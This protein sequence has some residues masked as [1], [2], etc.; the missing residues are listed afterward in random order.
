MKF[1]ICLIQPTGYIHSL[2][3]LEAA[4]YIFY[5]IKN[6]GY[7]VQ[8]VKNR[9]YPTG[10]NIIFG[11]HINPENNLDFPKNT[12]IFNTEQLP[13]N[14]DWVNKDYREILQK[15]FVWDYSKTNLDL[16]THPNKDLVNFYYEK[17]LIR[18]ALD[19]SKPYDLAF[20]GSINDRRKVI[21]DKLIAKGLKVKVI[22]GLYGKERDEAIK[23]CKAVLN[24]HFYESKIFQQIRAFYPL[25]NGIPVI[26]ENFPTESAPEIY[27]KVLFTP[28]DDD[29]CDYVFKTLKDS[30]LFNAKAKEKLSVFEKYIFEDEFDTALNTALNYFN[31]KELLRTQEEKFTKINLG[32]GKDYK[33]GYLN[34]DL[35]KEV[36]PDI[37]LDLS[38]QILF[39]VYVKSEHFGLIELAE[40]QFD[41]IIAN[42]VLEHVPNLETLMGN[43]LKVLK[44]GGKFII[45]VPYELSYG[46]WQDPTHIRGFNQN[47]WLYYTDW[48]WY[49]DWFEFRFHLSELNYTLSTYGQELL[50]N[51]VDERVLVLTPRAID[52]MRV[53]LTKI[54]TTPEEK[55]SAR[56]FFNSLIINN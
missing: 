24:L 3:L 32:S 47:S 11:A 9:I 17:A 29:F 18:I 26:S 16:I 45:N 12:I 27:Q 20:Y 2:A 51:G 52:S 28:H 44:T 38:N 46:A 41:E 31:S 49:L 4:E 15:S 5:K 35:R 10:I 39:P 6:N 14:P 50:K 7:D 1:N 42:D 40:G 13:E 54:E 48:F 33:R 23:D 30:S 43:C 22:F 55:T 21:L 37:L 36:L 56:S 8:L 34:I 19:D 25:I 53:V